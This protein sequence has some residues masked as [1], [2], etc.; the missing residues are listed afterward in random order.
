MSNWTR[1]SGMIYVS[2]MGRT[3]AEKRYVLDTVL[4]HLPIVDGSEGSMGIYVVQ[5]KGYNSSSSV[6]EFGFDTNNLTDWYGEKSSCGWLRCQSTYILVLD[7]SLRDREFDQTYRELQKFLCRLAKRV[8]VDKIMVQVSGWDKSVMI[9][10][11]K[12][13]DEMFEYPS[14]SIANDDGTPNWCEY[15][16]WKEPPKCY[17]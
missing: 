5:P 9:D 12:A 13:Y 6:D 16:M 3:Q 14:W 10:D 15:L 11:S 7:G 4:E 17:C 1:V 2:P 8:S